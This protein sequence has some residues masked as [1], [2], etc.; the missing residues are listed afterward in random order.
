[1]THPTG[2]PEMLE[3]MIGDGSA[4]CLYMIVHVHCIEDLQSCTGP[5]N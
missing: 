5:W 4:E 2:E 1:M 3:G